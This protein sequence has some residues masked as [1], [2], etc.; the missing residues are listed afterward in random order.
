MDAADVEKTAFCTHRGLFAWLVMPF[1]LCNAPAT[2]ERLMESVLGDLQWSKCLVYLDDI[3]SFGRDFLQAL[4]NLR[5]V[6]KRLRCA[7]LKL[8]PKKCQLFRKEV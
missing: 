2:F 7:G 8:K 1:S 6:F 5:E 3:I 4:D